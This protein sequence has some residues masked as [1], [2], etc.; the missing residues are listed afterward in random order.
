[1]YYYPCKFFWSGW[2]YASNPGPMVT[3]GATPLYLLKWNFINME[4]YNNWDIKLC[5]SVFKVKRCIKI[6]ALRL[7]LSN[8]I[9]L[10]QS[11]ISTYLSTYRC[12]WE[13]LALLLWQMSVMC[14]HAHYYDTIILPML[15][16]ISGGNELGLSMESSVTEPVIDGFVSNVFLCLTIF[17][18][19]VIFRTTFYAALADS[20]SNVLLWQ[21]CEGNFSCQ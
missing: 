16:K 9:P 1:M 17:S 21:C 10:F 4:D 18:T 6:F 15:Q 2:F 7:V 20:I 8:N 19:V 14:D 5:F 13:L 12:H 11:T 3:R